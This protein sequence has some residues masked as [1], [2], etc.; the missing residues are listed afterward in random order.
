MLC[1]LLARPATAQP[2]DLR[3]SAA[4]IPND[5]DL[6]VALDG[7]AEWRKGPSG[8][9]LTALLTGLLRTQ[10]GTAAWGRFA[11]QLGLDEEVAFDR[12]LGTHIVFANRADGPRQNWV[13]VST[14]DRETERLLRQKLQAAP[15]RVQQGLPIMAIEDG[16]F[17]IASAV[18]GPHAQI[19]LG[20]ATEQGLFD[21]VA[22]AVANPPRLRPDLPG[23][24]GQLLRKDA[25][26]RALVVARLPAEEG[27]W[28]GA[29]VTPDGRSFSAQFMIDSPMLATK[30]KPVEPWS[31]TAFDALDAN[32]FWKSIDWPGGTGGDIVKTLGLESALDW[33]RPLAALD[34]LDGR[35]ALVVSPSDD[36]LATAVLSWEA[37]D[38]EALAPAGDA[39]VSRAVAPLFGNDPNAPP[40][41]LGG[42]FPAA[43]RS[44]DLGQTP[45]GQLLRVMFDSGPV[46]SWS[47]VRQQA[48]DGPLARGWWTIGLGKQDV[49][50]VSRTLT[51]LEAEKGPR[52]PW[53]SLGAAR[54]SAFVRELKK[55]ALPLPE[56]VRPLL[57]AAALVER[58]EW[59]LFRSGD[60]TITGRGVLTLEAAP[61]IP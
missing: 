46:L 61:A 41:G 15:R 27:G 28:I 43:A 20:P 7:A 30:D 32:A 36:A 59:E 21:Q 53:V 50:E 51:G 60:R 1:A 8:P 37:S 24:A 52:L 49:S 31:R 18:R 29:T 54:P 13:L 39:A 22:A 14:I 16:R 45:A 33:A 3:A 40:V 47:F 5:V 58:I 26:A 48:P 12:L 4:V 35:Y 10:D 2:A 34:L 42:A 38:V 55:R 23:P 17:W 44:V 19:V 56:S 6:L 9:A 25:A 57:N 11:R